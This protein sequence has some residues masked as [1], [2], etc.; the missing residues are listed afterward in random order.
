MRDASSKKYDSM[1]CTI[2]PNISKF[3]ESCWIIKG[4]SS[5]RPGAPSMVFVLRSALSQSANA[6]PSSCN[7]ACAKISV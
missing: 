7:C 2:V 5:T 4:T 3:P 1:I 6:S